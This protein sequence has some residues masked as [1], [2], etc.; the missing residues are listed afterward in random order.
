[1]FPTPP[2]HHI[3]HQPSL[4][5]SPFPLKL[6]VNHWPP[7]NANNNFST[8]PL[9]SRSPTPS[10]SLTHSSTTALT[11]LNLTASTSSSLQIISTIASTCTNNCFN[12]LSSPL[13]L[14]ERNNPSCNETRKPVCEA[15]RV[16]GSYPVDSECVRVG[17]DNPVNNSEKLGSI[18]VAYLINLIPK[19]KRKGS[20]VGT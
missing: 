16:S 6:L 18:K 11:P 13:E 15:R 2:L 17:F 20:A 9:P 4:G 10:N 5:S 12:N 7:S 19:L 1:M 8:P 3:L 14:E